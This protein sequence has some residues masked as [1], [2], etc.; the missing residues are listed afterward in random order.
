[1]RRTPV[2]VVLCSIAATMT[3]VAVASAR[4][5]EW[6]RCVEAAKGVYRDA[7]CTEHVG[8]GESGKYQWRGASSIIKPGITA[9]GSGAVLEDVSGNTV[10]CGTITGSSRDASMGL[11]IETSNLQQARGSLSFRSCVDTKS[12]A[13]C[14][15]IKTTELRG[16][17]GYIF[18]AGTPDP[19]VGLG[20]K[21][22]SGSVF[23]VA[24]CP[25]AEHPNITIGRK[26]G[27][28]R[29]G[30]VIS[31]IEPVDEM[32]TSFTENYEQSGGV[33]NP[34]AFEDGSEYELESSFEGTK[35]PFVQAA[36]ELKYAN[37]SEEPIELRAY[38]NGC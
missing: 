36:L 20:M 4:L 8:K 30:S 15:E 12:G 37:I 23:A 26:S 3:C 17:L 14:G 25:G 21:P 29:G 19:S 2:V 10:R 11:T 22:V 7:G 32:T 28:R 38:C 24:S 9:Q 31:H 27:A 5:P 35:G 1:M 6:G 33:Q 13:S 16:T 34:T 18:G